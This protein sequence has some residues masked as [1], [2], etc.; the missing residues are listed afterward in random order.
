MDICPS[1]FDITGVYQ[2]IR[3]AGFR[4]LAADRLIGNRHSCSSSVF[5]AQPGS[6]CPAPLRAETRVLSRYLRLHSEHQDKTMTLTANQYSNYE[7]RVNY[8]FKTL[9]MRIP[10]APKNC[11]RILAHRCNSLV[12]Y[13]Y[14]QEGRVIW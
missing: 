6:R 11:P 3:A 4:T 9:R 12:C 8:C 10:I 13:S 14:G 1:Q 7:I 2:S 5:C